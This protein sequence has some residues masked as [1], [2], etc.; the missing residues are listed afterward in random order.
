MNQLIILAHPKKDSFTQQLKA[1]IV[2]QFYNQGNEV[3]VRDLYNLKFNPVLSA[4]ELKF[5][6]KGQFMGDVTVEQNYIRWADEISILYP[7]WWNAFPAILKG[8]I[9]RVFIN[10]FAFKINGNGPEGLLKGKGVRLITT[11][12]MTEESLT[13]SQVYEGLRITQDHGVFE[14][15]GMEVIDHLYVTRV[16]SLNE[17]EKQKVVDSLVKKIF[18]KNEIDAQ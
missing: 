13:E 2:D 7:L 12:G 14:F 3:K 5:N 1:E 10:G 8:Y 15:C 4:S 17:E 11:A 6:K 9:D 16:T 18:E